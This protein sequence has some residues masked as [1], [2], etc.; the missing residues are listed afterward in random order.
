MLC[1]V[2][3]TYCIAGYFRREFIFGYF[4]EAFLFENKFLVAVFLQKLIPIV[5]IKQCHVRISVYQSVHACVMAYW[6]S[7]LQTLES[8]VT[9]NL[10]QNFIDRHPHTSLLIENAIN[11]HVEVHMVLC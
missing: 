10:F 1:V 8:M 6:S 2:C 9:Q 7:Q 3:V 11:V 5:K 4:E